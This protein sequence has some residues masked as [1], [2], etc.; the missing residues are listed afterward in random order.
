MDA[1]DK[2]VVD[3]QTRYTEVD[4]SWPEEILRRAKNLIKEYKIIKR[5]IRI[6]KS[7]LK[8]DSKKA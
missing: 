1:K 4:F 5:G 2:K 6:K 8:K 7:S 3:D